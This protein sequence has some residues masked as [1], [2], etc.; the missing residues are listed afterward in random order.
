[1]NIAG[2][3]ATVTQTGMSIVRAIDASNAVNGQ[4]QTNA[5]GG[6]ENGEIA[7]VQ[8]DPPD[9]TLKDGHG[10]VQY[11]D[12]KVRI[13]GSK[14]DYEKFKTTFLKTPDKITDNLYADYTLLDRDKS[15]GLSAGDKIDI[16]I[17]GPYNG[18]VRVASVSSTENSFHATFITL[19]GHP[20][21]GSI[22]F[23]GRFSGNIIEFQIY[24]I[25]RSAE[26]G[27]GRIP[28]ATSVARRL[29][30]N[31]WKTVM[32]NFGDLFK[33]L[34]S[35][36]SITISKREWDDDA[37]QPGKWIDSTSEIA[38]TDVRLKQKF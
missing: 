18:S 17:I 37:G 16:D 31:Q 32:A 27:G 38:T 1:M 4:L 35:S 23:S 6:L 20:E 28:F 13:E 25:T 9:Q 14:D 26:I 8:Q 24:N 7:G 22:T 10:D 30:K 36:A 12:Y 3:V 33:K 34:V 11:Q 5:V 2:R 15:G 29:Q 21:A 19:D